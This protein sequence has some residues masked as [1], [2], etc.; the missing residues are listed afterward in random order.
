MELKEAT[1]VK[2]KEAE[3]KNFNVLMFNGKL[4]APHYILYL[5]SQYAIFSA[6]EDNH[7]LPHSDLNRKQAVKDDLNSLGLEYEYQ[8]NTPD[9]KTKL[10]VEYLKTLSYDEVLPHIYLNYLAIMFGGQMMK[11]KTPGTGKMYD[12]NDMNAAAGA[13]RAVQ[14]DDWADEVNK[15]FDFMIAIFDEL[16]KLI[17]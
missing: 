6:I 17:K 16:Y 10:Y 7:T 11:A 14:S 13:V 5:K 9:E 4:T 1:A 15:G 8:Y 2:H 12:F 3:R